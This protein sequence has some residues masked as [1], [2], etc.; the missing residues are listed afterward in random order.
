MDTGCNCHQP[1]VTVRGQM[2]ARTVREPFT[3]SLKRIEPVG[4]GSPKDL[5]E[6]TS[7]EIRQAALDARST[8]LK[9]LANYP[10]VPPKWREEAA[11]ITHE[12]IATNYLRA[13][14]AIR[15]AATRD[16]LQALQ[17]TL[18][19]RLAAGYAKP[20]TPTRDALWARLLAEYEIVTDA[21]AENCMWRFQDR[22]RDLE[23]ALG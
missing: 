20:P 10:Q 4:P 3:A 9:R 15:E 11:R 8:I 21:L 14:E 6:L 22:L 5:A 16:E 7:P 19:H 23:A 12:R 1:S 13:I 2:R 18:Q 17:A